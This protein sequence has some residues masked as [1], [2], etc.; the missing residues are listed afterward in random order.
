LHAGSAAKNP[1]DSGGERC[2]STQNVRP[3]SIKVAYMRLIAII[4]PGR[5]MRTVMITNP[6]P[7]G[8]PM[9]GS[10]ACRVTWHQNMYV[11]A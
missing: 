6:E 5:Y 3:G 9:I 4:V 1:G 10:V 8:I 11:R 2:S 7:S